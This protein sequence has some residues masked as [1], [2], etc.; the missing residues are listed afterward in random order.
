MN[1]FSFEINEIGKNAWSCLRLVLAIRLCMS[2]FYIDALHY[3]WA[4]AC[5]NY[6]W[7]QLGWVGFDTHAMCK[8][9]HIQLVYNT[10]GA[11]EQH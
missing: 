3:A 5:Y 2:F 8:D 1:V 4:P 6:R 7:A 9:S 11:A 10:G